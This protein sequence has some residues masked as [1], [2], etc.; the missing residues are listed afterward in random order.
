MTTALRGRKESVMHAQESEEIAIP[1]EEQTQADVPVE[2]KPKKGKKSKRETGQTMTLGQLATKYI[3]S[4]EE[5]G[6][7]EGTQFSY[8][9]ELRT[10]IKHLGED[11]LISS[12]TAD[13]VRRY[14]ECDAVM[15]L[16][17]G[18]PKAMPS[19]AKT[20]RVLRLALCFAVE[21]KWLEVA[22]LPEPPPESK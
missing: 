2:P 13:G 11:T 14:F 9:I 18:R 7:S 21:R 1:T 4:L 20:Q 15:K 17:S 3:D 5:S 12:L 6:K 16:K 19:Y 8:R 10:A 22:P